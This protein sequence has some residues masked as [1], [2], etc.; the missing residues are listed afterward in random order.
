MQ[1]D[2]KIHGVQLIAVSKD[3]VSQA[4]RQK[5]RDGLSFPLLSDEKLQVI[6]A[7]GLE[8]HKALEFSTLSFSLFGL[9]LA[10]VPS[11]KTMA[12]P[13]TLLIDEKGVIRWIDQSEDYR[14]RSSE[15]R[16]LKAVDDAF[17]KSAAA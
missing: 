14:L 6:R 16:I 1:T 5:D 13:T 15:E 9:P 10:L 17:G 3:S 8:H 11:V 7:Y 2:L 4:A 12:I